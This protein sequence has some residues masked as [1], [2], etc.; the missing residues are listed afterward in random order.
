[1]SQR[2]SIPVELQD[3][4]RE[5]I[6]DSDVVVTCT[7]KLHEPIYKNEWV[8]PGALVLP[9]HSSGWEK[10]T[11]FVLDKF[12]VDDWAQFSK[13][14]LG[15]H[16]YYGRL[17]NPDAELGEIVSHKK[18]G[19]TDSTQRILNHNY[20]MAIHDVLMAREILARARLKGLGVVLPLMNREPVY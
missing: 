10:D 20:G 1:M 16:G 6:R 9:I 13:A 2:I 8:K 12:V 3:S 19:R 17:P 7:G 14:Q 15:E 11:P 5:V 18:T 4:A